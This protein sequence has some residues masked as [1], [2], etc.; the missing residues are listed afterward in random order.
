MVAQGM[1][2]GLPCYYAHAALR[3]EHTSPYSMHCPYQGAALLVPKE[4]AKVLPCSSPRNLPR[5]GLARAK[6]RPCFCPR[7]L[8][9]RGLARA[10][11]IC[12][13]AAL[14]M[15]KE[16]V[17]F[18]LAAQQERTMFMTFS[19]EYPVTEAE[20]R[21]Y[22]TRTYGDCIDSFHIE[23]VEATQQALYA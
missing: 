3:R 1:L 11:G 20:V 6:V 21:D 17:I 23:E 18:I 9:R 12:Q 4:S 13:G 8:Q 16:V 5:R 10:K 14:L 19:R 15:P 7:N 2:E 22:F